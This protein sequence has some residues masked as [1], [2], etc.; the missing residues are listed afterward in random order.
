VAYVQRGTG[1]ARPQE[2]VDQ[3]PGEATE[4]MTAVAVNM[5]LR[6]GQAPAREKTLRASIAR[7]RRLPPLWDRKSGRIDMYYWHWG[8]L[9]M[10][11]AGGQH[12]ET[13][14]AAMTKAIVDTQ[15]KDGDACSFKGSWDPVGPWGLDGGRIYSTALMALCLEARYRYARTVPSPR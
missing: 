12:L 1:P 4:S 14:R 2:L 11:Q 13:W 9:A 3:F 5:R 10:F 6:M 7:V 8:A 15:R